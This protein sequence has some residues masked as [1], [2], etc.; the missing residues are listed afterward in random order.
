M[1]K[2]FPNT[3]YHKPPTGKGTSGVGR[4]HTWSWSIS[5]SRATGQYRAEAINLPNSA[6]NTHCTV[7]EFRF[8]S[9]PPRLYMIFPVQWRNPP[10]MVLKD[11]GRLWTMGR[12]SFTP[13]LNRCKLVAGGKKVNIEQVP[14]RRS[15][16]THTH[17]LREESGERCG[18]K[19]KKRF[20]PNRV[21]NRRALCE[22]TRTWPKPL[23]DTVVIVHALLAGQACWG[24]TVVMFA[25]FD[26][27]FKCDYPGDEKVIALY[28]VWRRIQGI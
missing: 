21:R 20:V 27:S 23:G 6:P 1:V 15:S 13:H 26:C 17:S 16:S 7:G 24:R 28:D 10:A 12:V 8:S 11:A 18:G 4:N 2:G 3:L 22:M 9:R 5:Y 14:V 19:E 25:G